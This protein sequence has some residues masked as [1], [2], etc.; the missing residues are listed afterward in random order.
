MPYLFELSLVESADSDVA[1]DGQVGGIQFGSFFETFPSYLPSG[2]KDI[3][4]SSERERLRYYF[5]T[6]NCSPQYTSGMSA[7]QAST[8][9][10]SL[11]WKKERGQKL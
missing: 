7:L 6:A 5:I 11:M 3:H 8:T 4:Q 1:L 9:D 10:F 2:E